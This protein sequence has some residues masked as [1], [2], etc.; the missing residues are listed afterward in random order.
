MFVSIIMSG[1]LSPSAITSTAIGG[2]AI[3]ISERRIIKILM[4]TEYAFFSDQSGFVSNIFSYDPDWEKPDNFLFVEIL[5]LL[6]RNRKRVG[7][8][9]LEGYFTCRSVAQDLQKFGYVPED[10]L[11]A[12]NVLLNRQLI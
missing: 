12:L 10:T 3:S 11:R 6:Q 9:G 2:G 7:Q 8:I 1:H 4:R 5:Y